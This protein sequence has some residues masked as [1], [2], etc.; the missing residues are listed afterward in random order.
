MAACCKPGS[1]ASSATWARA[2]V[3][4]IPPLTTQPTF[5]TLVDLLGLTTG[6]LLESFCGIEMVVVQGK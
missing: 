6:F 3:M 2:A 4:R 1:A 5:D